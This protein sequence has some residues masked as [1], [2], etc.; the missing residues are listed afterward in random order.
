MYHSNPVAD[1]E[2]GFTRVA[3]PPFKN[4]KTK[5]N[6]KKTEKRKVKREEGRSENKS[7]RDFLRGESEICEVLVKIQAEERVFGYI[8]KKHVRICCF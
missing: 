3:P 6:T 5:D 4:A 7:S 2:M 1:P 8:L